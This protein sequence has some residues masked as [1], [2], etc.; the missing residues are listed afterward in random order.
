M[1]DPSIPALYYLMNFNDFASSV[2]TLFCLMVVNN[3]FNTT[4]ML[5]DV[6]G[7]NW[8]ILFTFSFIV[9]CVWIMLS[10]MIAF[11][12]EIHGKVN[13]EVEKEWKRRQWVSNLSTAWTGQL[14][15]QVVRALSSNDLNTPIP[16]PSQGLIDNLDKIAQAKNPEFRSSSLNERLPSLSVDS[17]KP[18][19]SR[20]AN[21]DFVIQI[22]PKAAHAS[23]I[24]VIMEEAE[25][26]TA[27]LT[28]SN[29]I[30][31]AIRPTAQFFDES[32][33]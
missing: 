4:N 16:A 7:N 11:V 9:I 21:E 29:D 32:D 19:R 13:E 12:L 10:V 24:D 28:R 14:S 23:K 1:N 30:G 17:V 6:A 18:Q 8:P 26:E 22:N 5:C 3:W 20:S 2:I 25:E 31:R 27:M 15:P 33:N